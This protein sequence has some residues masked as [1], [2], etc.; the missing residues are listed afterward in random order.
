[1]HPD[2]A[3][4]YQVGLSLFNANI[5]AFNRFADGKGQWLVAARRSNLDEIADLV[6]AS[7]GELRYSD[8]F[9]RVDYEF[10]PE[11]RG[12]LHVLASSDR[13]DVTNAL[14]TESA[15][16]KYRNSYAWV[17]LEHDFSSALTARAIASYTYV[18]TDR[19][20]EVDEENVRT[21][22]ADDHRHYDVAGLILAASYST[23]R[24][25]TRF[26]G[27]VR[28]LDATYDY[29]S[30]VHFEPGYPFPGSGE[31]TRVNDLSPTPSGRHYALYAT[32]R[33]RIAEPLTAEIGLRWDDET[34]T[35]EGSDQLGP[36]VNLLYQASPTTLLRASW[37][38]YEQSQGIN[39]LQVE[40]GVDRFFRP[41]RATHEILG[42]EQILPQGFT[43]R[44][45]GYIKDYDQPRLRFESLYDP[46]SL[47]PELRWDRVAIWPNSS[48]A[49]GVE[50]LLTRKSDS[51]WNGWFNYA[52][53]RVYDRREGVNTVRSWDQTSN[54]GGGITWSQGSWQATLAATYH[55]GWPTTPARLVGTIPGSQSVS[56]GPRNAARLGSYSSVDARVSR[57]FELPRGTLNVFAEVSNVLDRGNPCCTDFSY[58]TESDGTAI[59]EHEYRNWLPLIPNVGVLWKF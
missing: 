16:A 33:V 12:S 59:L 4:Q 3:Q 18:K 20:G 52:W 55:T 17:T 8:A 49:K 26:G 23:D 53:S 54:V 40:D 27:E 31:I 7:Y 14:G 56:I 5:F 42:L 36:R 48:R 28:W 39:E 35:P 46:T 24:W 13:A 25:L 6:D 44:L 41:Q 50:F 29:S 15:E 22:S 58:E 1:V 30:V 45:E 38:V 47:V 32:T 2:V 34:Y 51:P 21:G 9:A 11:T 10:T 57:D 43:L 37:G 19:Q